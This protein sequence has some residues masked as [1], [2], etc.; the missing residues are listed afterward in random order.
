MKIFTASIVC[1]LYPLFCWAHPIPDIPVIGDFER[2]GKA[3][4]IVEVD[5]R[6]FAEDPEEVPFLQ[7]EAFDKL[8]EKEKKELTD[9]ARNLLQETLR[10]RFGPEEW[11]FPEF[12]FE[13]LTKEHETLILDGDVIVLRGILERTLSSDVKSYQ[14][15]AMDSAGYDIVFKN[16]LAGI[17]QKRV[18]VLWPGEESFALDLSSFF[19]DGKT[20]LAQEV[21]NPKNNGTSDTASTFYSFLRKGFVHVLPEGLDHILFVIGLFLFSRKTKP[22]L[23]Q[24]TAF[25]IAHTIT[26]ALASLNFIV[27]SPSIV[28]PL[29]ALSIVL[30]AIENV[31]LR[32][33]AVFFSFR[34]ATVFIFGLIHGLGFAGVSSLD[35]ES[36]SFIAELLGFTIGVDFGQIAVI[37]IFLALLRALSVLEKAPQARFLTPVCFN[38]F[39]IG[40]IAIL[41]FEGTPESCASLVIWYAGLVTAC[42]SL[43]FEPILT[44]AIGA[45]SLI[46]QARH[47]QTFFVIPGSVFIGFIGC[48]WTIERI[49]F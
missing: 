35:P 32:K 18:N 25:T 6:C 31:L 14:I 9:Q 42:L 27:I 8:D 17:P 3:V 4:I 44:K 19:T 38:F 29:I 34:L 48:Y 46:K 2:N 10:M 22:L 16:I 39:L 15:K 5:P 49:F 1:L 11:F 37:L 7:K 13:F 40:A 24:V 21:E 41:F 47:Y 20:H 45:G 36:P 23:L 30:L 33:I 28:E 43:Q 26:I 12:R